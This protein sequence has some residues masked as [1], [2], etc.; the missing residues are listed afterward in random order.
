MPRMSFAVSDDSGEIVWYDADEKADLEI[1][2][3]AEEVSGEE[4]DFDLW[5]ETKLLFGIALPAVAVQFSVLF[6][7][8]Q[9]ASIVG[10]SLGTEA[11]AGFSLGSLV[12]NLTCL[13]VMVGA[14]TAAD[15]LMPRAYG[16]GSYS[17]VGRLAI[18]G[19]VVCSLLLV[20]PIIPLCTVMEWVFN[21]LG[22]D[23]FASHLASEWVKIY[24]IGVPAML[25][26]RVVQ[27]F[28]N[29]QHKVWPLVFASVVASFLVHPIILRICIS[30][31]G[32]IGSSL[33]ICLTQYVMAV[34]LLLY[35][36]FKPVHKKETW[37]GLST[38]YFLEAISPRPMMKFLSLSLGGVLALSVSSIVGRKTNTSK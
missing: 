36:W 11:L 23:E 25:L 35:L 22:Q 6:I 20:G 3:H 2:E 27:S 34:F 24:L 37:P 31:L 30:H 32:F 17:E 8:P 18:R 28:L 26:F 29:A 9:T 16:A 10:R 4:E 33:A 14:L 12:G 13:S 19:F 5:E 38:S 21:M 15:T 7:F 1:L